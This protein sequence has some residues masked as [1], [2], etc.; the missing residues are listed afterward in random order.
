MWNEALRTIAIAIRRFL[1]GA[2]LVGGAALTA[3][4]AWFGLNLNPRCITGCRGRPIH[5]A[6]MRVKATQEAV[7][8]YMIETPSCPRSVDDLVAGRYLDRAN[9]RDPWGSRL[10]L[11]CPGNQDHEGADV[12][13]LGPDKELGTA[14]DIQSWVL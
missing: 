9:A 14:D 1:L 6:K 7:T 2:A 4:V 5:T 8:Q 12:V 11:L 13:S 10:I 3:R